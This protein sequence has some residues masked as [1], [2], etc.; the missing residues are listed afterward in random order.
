M[1]DRDVLST[2]LSALESY[3]AE[4]RS[5]RRHS[6]GEFIQEPALH[7]LAERFLH[8][9]SECVLDIVHHIIADEGYRQPKSYKDAI[10]VLA[11][12]KVVE[13]ELGEQIKDWIGFRNVLVHFYLDIDHGRS[14]DAIENDL[15]SLE[16]LARALA[17]LLEDPEE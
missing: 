14:Y 13:A 11:E 6:R 17:P 9:A 7:H 16:E 2:R 5:F 10:D 1:V 15:T 3:L 8:L 12:E 4:L